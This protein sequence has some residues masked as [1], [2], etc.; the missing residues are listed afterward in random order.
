M[1]LVMSTHEIFKKAPAASGGGDGEPPLSLW[2]DTWRALDEVMPT[3]REE[4]FPDV[5]VDGIVSTP[6]P[7][8]NTEEEKEHVASPPNREESV[9]EIAVEGGV[10][11]VQD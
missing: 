9:E 1:L 7:V 4:L 11:I 8:P 3:L 10:V 2:Q 5:P 6:K